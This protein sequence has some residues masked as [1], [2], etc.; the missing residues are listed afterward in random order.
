L[1]GLHWETCIVYLDDM[2]VCGK[3]FEDM[4]KNLDEVFARLQEAGLK[5]KARKCQL[6]ARKVNFLGHV[7][8]EDGICTDP[9]KTEC[10]R[11]WPN[12][13]NVKEVRS[14]LGFCSYYRRFIFRFAEIAKPLHKLTQ[15]GVRFTWTS[16]C[17]N[18]FQ[19]L[20][21]K[22]VNAPVLAHP[23]F[24]QSFILD[25]DACDQSIGAVISQ[26]IN[27]EE[28]AV[29]FASRTLTKSERAY[30]VTRKELLALVTFVK[31]YKHYLYGKKF[32][33]RTDHS[34][35]KW[36]MNFKNPEGQI[37]R[38]IETLSCYDMKV[39]HRPGRL[40]QNADGVSRIPCT[41]CGVNE[42]TSSPSVNVVESSNSDAFD[43][44]KIQN[45]D[46]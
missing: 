7:I 31:H 20:K 22:L 38:W 14:F 12:P 15:K 18:A 16:E 43:L 40:H 19:S 37:A 17:Q 2:I 45:S 30:C 32:L 5:L 29:G 36:L 41:Q 10:V 21:T 25:V 23:D 39:E 3:T 13:T 8:S 28:H 4:V 44:K 46:R 33:V 1:A 26:K 34:S 42:E 11:N 35:L 27:G 9:K 6:F 24:S